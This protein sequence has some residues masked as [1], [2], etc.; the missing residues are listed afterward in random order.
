MNKKRFTGLE[1]LVL[2]SQLGFTIAMPI[3]LGALAGRWI[4][5]KLGTGMTFMI[6]LLIT[7]VA[8]GIYGAYTQIMSVTKKRK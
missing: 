2:C 8:A 4:D 7:G 1:A 5:S 6:V 3:V